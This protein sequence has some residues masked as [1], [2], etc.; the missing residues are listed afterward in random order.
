M[1]LPVAEARDR[2]CVSLQTCHQSKP[3]ACRPAHA[4]HR[5][6]AVAVPKVQTPL[7]GSPSAPLHSQPPAP[8]LRSQTHSAADANRETAPPSQ[9]RTAHSTHTP[10][11]DSARPLI[12][13]IRRLDS[14]LETLRCPAFPTPRRQPRTT[15]ESEASPYASTRGWC[16]PTEYPRPTK[17]PAMRVQEH[18]ELATYGQANRHERDLRHRMPPA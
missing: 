14:P 18:A 7:L 17:R 16:R 4:I 3:G 11:R 15:H 9:G 10:G 12:E 8:S 1:Y 2:R 6:P 13:T 5:P